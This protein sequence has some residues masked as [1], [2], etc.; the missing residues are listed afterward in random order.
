VNPDHALAL[1]MGMLQATLVLTG[2]ILAA[3]LVSGVLVGV[4]QTA[5]QINEASVGYV[6]KA[7][8]VILTL[9]ALGPTMVERASTYARH[10]LEAIGTL[11]E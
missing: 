4:V 6:V 7:A 3:T 1:M 2:P 5:T 9:L 8:A 11:V 10:S